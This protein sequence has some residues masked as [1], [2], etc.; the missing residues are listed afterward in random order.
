MFG[1][2]L[3]IWQRPSGALE[4]LKALVS[5][6]GGSLYLAKAPT[7][8]TV[9]SDGSGGLIVDDGTTQNVGQWYDQ[10]ASTHARQSS[11]T[12]K[13]QRRMVD[14]GGGN[15]QPASVFDGVDDALW[16]VDL[17][18]KATETFL[19]CAV[20]P[21][22]RQATHDAFYSKRR[23][24]PAQQGVVAYRQPN[25]DN[26]VLWGGTGAVWDILEFVGAVLT[27]S[28]FGHVIKPGAGQSTSRCNGVASTYPAAVIS[29]PGPFLIGASYSG[30]VPEYFGDSYIFGAI[31]APVAIPN[32]DLIQIEKLL[33]RHCLNQELPL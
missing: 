22:Q 12:A 30:T 7:I 24:L 5:K 33:Y 6:Y 10:C 23:T 2:G 32:N 8:G 18:S 4:A 13:P 21:A 1:V 16:T 25:T 19:C 31:Y 14:V 9:N 3:G 20:M 26:L 28:V 17:P 11:S 29:S 27:P 15:L